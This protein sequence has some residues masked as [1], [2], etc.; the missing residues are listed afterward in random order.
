MTLSELQAKRDEILNSLGIARLEF[1]ERSVQYAE[2]QQALALI[3]AEIAKASIATERFSMART[4]K[5]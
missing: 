5:G 2:Q 1:G 3:D 4:S